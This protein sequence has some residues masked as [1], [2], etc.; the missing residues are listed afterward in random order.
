[1]QFRS[2]QLA[3]IKLADSPETFPDPRTALREPDGLLAAGGD[4]SPARLLYAYRHGIF[5]WYN[6]GQPILWWCPDPRAV[7]F[8]NALHVSHSLRKTLRQH[9]YEVTL[10][11]AFPEVMHACAGA[12]RNQPE[13]GTWITNAMRSAYHA[14]HRMGH[15]HSVEVWMDGELSGGLYGV[16][17][18]GVFFGESMFSLRSNASK[19]ALAWLT[20]QLAAWGFALMDC[21]VTSAH[22]ARLGSVN[23]PRAEFLAQL[24]TLAVLPTRVGPW[25]MEI[26]AEF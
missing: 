10:D 5:P 20:R 3:W 2:P 12:R 15:A 18:G 17:L 24:D 4:L 6:E 21:Q 14:L 25:Q 19:I 7:L 26:V 22:L 8:P 23:L 11:R 9:H 16:A 13:A 1:M